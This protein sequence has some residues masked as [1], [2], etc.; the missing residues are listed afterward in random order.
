M[1]LTHLCQYPGIILSIMPAQQVK[2][3]PYTLLELYRADI[4]CENL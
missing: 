3:L 1:H 2:L 4:L